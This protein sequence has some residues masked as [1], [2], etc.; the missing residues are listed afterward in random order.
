VPRINRANHA[1]YQVT[2][3]VPRQPLYDDEVFVDDASTD[4][5]PPNA[6]DYR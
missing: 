5:A 4:M 1:A 2:T 6:D 3:L